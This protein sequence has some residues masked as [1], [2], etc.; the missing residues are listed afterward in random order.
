VSTAQT[1]TFAVMTFCKMP[2]WNTYGASN[3]PLICFCQGLNISSGFKPEIQTC[4]HTMY[5]WR[6]S[7]SFIIFFVY[8]IDLLAHIFPT[9]GVNSWNWHFL[10]CPLACLPLTVCKHKHCVLCWAHRDVLSN[11]SGIPGWTVSQRELLF[12]NSHATALYP[13][14]SSGSKGLLDKH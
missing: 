6:K 3:S 11:M 4:L 5:S 12:T 10:N 9:T 14:L 13:A 2:W 7:L 8:G 1:K